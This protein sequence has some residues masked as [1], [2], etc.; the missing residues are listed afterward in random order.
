MVEEV[1]KLLAK[2]NPHFLPKLDPELL[3]IDDPELLLED[4]PKL[5]FED[6]LEPPRIFPQSIPERSGGDGLDD[7]ADDST[8]E[9]YQSNIK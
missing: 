1:S 4:D 6:E 8:K 3:P 5:L 2:D 7:R 9:K